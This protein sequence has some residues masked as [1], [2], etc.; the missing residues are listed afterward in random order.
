MSPHDGLHGENV[1]QE[2]RYA[3]AAL[4]VV[5]AKAD[6]EEH[7]EEISAIT[8]LL[9]E[10]FELEKKIIEELMECVDEE[11]GVRGLDEF[12]RLV[13]QHYS[14]EDKLILVGNLWRVAHADGRVDQF[15][16]QFI[17]RV[18]FMIDVPQIQVKAMR[19]NAGT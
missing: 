4:L 2:I 18:A 13:N 7:P 6:F 16:E 1:A 15:E 19:R 17:S 8:K 12:T 11:T 3:A 14:E 5:C 9:E 10:T